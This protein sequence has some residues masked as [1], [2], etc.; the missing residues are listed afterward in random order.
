MDAHERWVA[1]PD[2]DPSRTEFER[3]RG[4]VL[5]SS[6][7]RRL[8]AKTQVLG[9]ES[10]DF[11]RTRLT[12]SL[13]VAQIGRAL[14]TNLGADPDVVETSC[15]SHDL[16][17]PPYGHNGERALAEVAESCGG[18]EGNAQTLR[19]LTRL[20]PKRTSPGGRPVGLNLTRATL[21]AVVKYP[22]GPGRGPTRPDGS[23]S[24]K[25]GVYDEDRDV[26]SWI[27]AGRGAERCIEAQ[28]MDL[29]DDIA[30]SV[31]DVEDGVVRG[32][33]DAS[34]LWDPAEQERVVADATAWY[35]LADGAALGDAL[36]R[37]R[38]PLPD[39]VLLDGRHNWWA[40]GSLFDL[41]SALPH[42]PVHMRVRADA[43]C[44]AVAAASVVAKVE[45]DAMM[46]ALDERH[47]GYDW[48][49]NK[50][51]ASPAH[52]RGLARLGPSAHHRT[53]W[54][55]PGVTQGEAT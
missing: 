6:A 12:H 13:E 30:Y 37:L 46:V 10:D 3:D 25:F 28:M 19:I 54:H 48:A 15:L 35:G 42:I 5:H 22:W 51:Y 49:R 53:S 8:G 7:L 29:A 34:A 18:F 38:G 24:P 44:S 21:D 27:R 52:I 50:G 40:D 36:D 45:R 11:I 33:I 23:T 1:E 16:G 26:F 39:A 2:K 9:P 4:R 47:P 41:D 17:H 43:S 20:E 14:A 31:H 55:L 32:L